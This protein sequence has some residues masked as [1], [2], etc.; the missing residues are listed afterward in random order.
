M[1]NFF[2]SFIEMKPCCKIRARLIKKLED[3]YHV[4]LEVECVVDEI[5]R[6][7]STYVPLTSLDPMKDGIKNIER[8]ASACFACDSLKHFV[9]Y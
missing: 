2:L 8:S 4:V 9:T 7:F 6:D 1:A 5:S 3:T